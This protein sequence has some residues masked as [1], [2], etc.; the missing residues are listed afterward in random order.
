M[1]RTDWLNHA[2]SFELHL[3]P[4]LKHRVVASKHEIREETPLAGA[5]D[6]AKGKTAAQKQTQKDK[7]S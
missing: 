1:L 4:I 7:N 6:V 5:D 2:I 3:P